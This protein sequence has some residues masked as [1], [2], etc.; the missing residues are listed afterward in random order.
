MLYPMQELFFPLPKCH[1]FRFM[2]RR[3]IFLQPVDF[4]LERRAITVVSQALECP[5]AI[6]GVLGG[7]SRLT[8]DVPDERGFSST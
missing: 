1:D 4:P 7:G 5:G 2:P 3:A 8:G 6:G